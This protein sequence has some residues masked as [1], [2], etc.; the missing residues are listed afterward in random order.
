VAEASAAEGRGEGVNA[1]TD[2]DVEIGAEQA[3][4]PKIKT[5]ARAQKMAFLF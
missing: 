3:L 2:G 1:G 5:N 4:S